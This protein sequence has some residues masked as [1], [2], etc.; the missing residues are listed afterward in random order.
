MELDYPITALTQHLI[1][2]QKIEACRDKG[3]HRRRE[4]Y[5]EPPSK[6]VRKSNEIST[7]DFEG[8]FR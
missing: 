6:K 4:M 3:R 1:N 8:L 2:R 7:I 5:E